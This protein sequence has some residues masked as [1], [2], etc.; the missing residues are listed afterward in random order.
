M[1]ADHI[2]EDN[3]EWPRCGHTHGRL[4]QHSRQNN[5]PGCRGMASADS[6]SVGTRGPLLNECQRQ[7]VRLGE[8][9]RVY[10]ATIYSHPTLMA[11]GSIGRNGTSMAG[12]LAPVCQGG[13]QFAAFIHIKRNLAMKSS[14]CRTLLRLAACV[15]ISGGK[16]AAQTKPAADLIITN[17][18]VWTVDKS[19]PAQK[20]SPFWAT[21]LSRS[22]RP[23]RSMAGADRGRR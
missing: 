15:F 9:K 13:V 3:L 20:P 4:N 6:R 18:K 11:S 5:R 2:V 14:I 12:R 21:G 8:S 19:L 16:S 10:R 1:H 23:R 17:A 22:V 7:A